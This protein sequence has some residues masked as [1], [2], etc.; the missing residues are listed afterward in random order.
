MKRSEM[1]EYL[2]KNLKKKDTCI[3]TNI[4]QCRYLAKLMLDSVETKGMAP[5]YYDKIQDNNGDKV[6]IPCRE[7]EKE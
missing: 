5:P 6:V 3:T 1:L 7:W 4:E 2:A